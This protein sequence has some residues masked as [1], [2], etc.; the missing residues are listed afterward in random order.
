MP[1]EPMTESTLLLVE[2]DPD[3]LEILRLTFTREGYKV[4]LA[5]DGEEALILARRHLPDLVVL[6]LMLPR[7]DGLEVCREIRADP[8]LEH[9]LVLMLTAKAE[10][11]DV[12]LGL[13]LGADDYVTKPARPRE[14]VARVRTLLRRARPRDPAVNDRV[15]SFGRLVIDPVRFE[16]RTGEERVRLTPT[17]FRLL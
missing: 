7:K 17:E 11:T 5:R 6:D 13:G 8:A 14:L 15:L 1:P 3:L 2:D 16:V 12:V 4:V 10:E 9:V